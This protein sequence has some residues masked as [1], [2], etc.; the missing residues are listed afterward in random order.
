MAQAKPVINIVFV[1][2][3]DHGKSTLLG[4]L[5]YDSGKIPEQELK[6]ARETAEKLGKKGF[7]FAYLL[8]RLKE[9]RERGVTIDL[10]YKKITTN[11]YEVTVID[12]PGHRD[13][14]KNMITGASQ[15][16]AAFLVV[17]VAEGIMAQ[18]K[19][20]IHLC[21]TMGVEQICVVFNKMDLVDYKEEA[22]K[23]LKEDMLAL[24]KTV[25]YNT[26]KINFIPVSAIMGE[27]VVKKSEKMKWYTG[28]TIMEQLDLFEMPK[29]PIELP[30]RMP[31]E[32]VY[33][34]T[35]V[36][37]VPVGKIIS[38][39]MKVGQ[40][41]IILPGRSGKG[42][43][44]EVKTIEA[45]HEAMP[46][47]MAGDNVGVNI[48]GVSK[49]DIARGDVIADAANPPKVV[50]EFTAKIVVINIKRAIAPG[51]TPVFHTHTA[52]VPCQFIE[53]IRTIDPKTGG[54]LK[55]KPDFLKNGD[56]AEVKLKPKMPMVIEKNSDNPHMARFAIRDAGSTVAAGVCTNVVEKK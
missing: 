38:G 31:V 17:N 21:Y 33:E 47:A 10:A 4:R 55:D 42:I 22:Y 54:T 2:H 7:E 24:I 5:L 14:V 26:T 53:I 41:V 1:G 11:K 28:P 56:M 35:G 36:G 49:K 50:E 51:Y 44:G 19:E 45:H 6:K 8:D 40:K 43:S 29:K 34:I 16:D 39:K 52:Q 27:G 23:K 30:L 15:A 37:V 9:E 18:T 3:V 48:R 12:A 25:G 46:E 32:N 20:H 13:F